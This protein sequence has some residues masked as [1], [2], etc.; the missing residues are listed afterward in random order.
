MFASRPGSYGI[1]CNGVFGRGSDGYKAQH[2]SFLW[3]TQCCHEAFD[4]VLENGLRDEAAPAD[5]IDE[6]S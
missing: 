3:V 1:L 6:L 4:I 2:P 5:K